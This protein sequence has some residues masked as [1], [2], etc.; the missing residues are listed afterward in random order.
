LFERKIFTSYLVPAQ[1]GNKLAFKNILPAGINK[2]DA[3]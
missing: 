3:I 1:L 2:Q